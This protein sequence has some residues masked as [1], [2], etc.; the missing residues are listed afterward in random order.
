[1][2]SLKHD[3]PLWGSQLHLYTAVTVVYLGQLL[4]S[5]LSLPMKRVT[6]LTG[7]TWGRDKKE[8]S[9]KWQVLCV[10]WALPYAG[11]KP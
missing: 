8:M 1:M 2:Q 3:A 7:W 11:S 5:I 6:Y 10:G 4:K 9:S